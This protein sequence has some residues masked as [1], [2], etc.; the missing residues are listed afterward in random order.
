MS[1]TKSI[2]ELLLESAKAIT[3]EIELEKLVQRVTDI[4]TE[5]SGAQFG[6]FFYNVINQ[7][8][9]AFLLYTIS[10]VAKEAFSKFPN[11]RNTKIFSPT[12]SAEGT[13]RYDDVTKQPEYGQNAPYHGMPKGHL[14]VRSY[15]A[16]PVVSPFTN[17]A[18]GGLFF[19]HPEPGVFTEK[20]ERL[21]EGVAIQAAIAMGNARLFEEK[22]QI[23]R[24][25]M[26]QKE[27]Y[28]SIFNAASDSIII[29]DE[30]GIIAEANPSAC[31]IFGYGYDEL[32]GSHAGRLF[33][34]PQDFE[35]LKEIALSGRQYS[36]TSI[37]IKKDGTAFEAEFKGSHFIFR[38]KPHVMSAVKESPSEREAKEVQQKSEELA[39]I[40]TSAAPVTLWMTNSKAETIYINQTWTDWVG[41][42]R[43]DQLGTGWLN[44]ILPE[45]REQAEKLFFSAFNARK[46]FTSDFRIRRR[47]GE[48][49]WCSTHGTPYYKDGAFA[50]YTGSLTDI[51]DRKL[52]EET[53][54]KQSNLIN[55]I[56]DNTQQAMFLMDERHFCTYMN[57]AAQLM[58]GFT[59]EE[60]KDK[61]LHYYIH[62]TRPDGRHF[63]SD[64]CPIDNSIRQKGYAQGEETFIH[65]DGHFYPVAYVASPI[66]ENGVFKGSVLE[67]RN[68]TEEKRLQQ[69]LR[70]KEKEAMA[71]LEE[72]V[73]ERTSELERS[74][75]ELLQFASVASHDLKE[76]VRKISIFSGRLKDKIHDSLDES[77]SRYLNTIIDSSQRMAGL[78]DDLLSF[79]RLS[80]ADS[81]FEEVDLGSIAQRIIEDLEIPIKEKE[82]EI[83]FRDL[84]VL[85]G[86][87]VQLGQVFQNLVSNSLKF[88]HP[89]R[90]LRIDITCEKFTSVDRTMYRIWYRDNGIGFG[91][92]QA[93]KIFE[94]F[95]RLHSKDKYEGTGVGLA[96]VKKII[97]LHRGEVRAEGVEGEGAVFE[98]VLPEAQ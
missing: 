69:E 73:R 82:A 31:R 26:E 87:P 48:V 86:I 9:E 40:I 77:T 56:T 14:P 75:Y 79:S 21:I 53:L 90:K 15:L 30:N 36:G 96:I 60:L 67:I 44:S 46:V 45:D 83:H 8:G 42:N 23:E 28:L 55:T 18:I 35:A 98:I 2:V 81:G 3:S 6:A 95:Y 10:G 52:A 74:N 78:I 66:I 24:T 89:E 20:S 57:P 70:N 71:M 58:T 84:P 5:L 27:Q 65:K 22:K 62:H 91:P 11:P 16:V 4:G 43:E 61:P 50:G 88:S 19:G 85:Q 93:E 39:N 68:T 92:E 72:K 97:S 34:N 59:V 51:T 76:P 12:F 17:E 49:R 63:P 33:R 32:I 38:G 80:H 37:R 54:E 41:G 29:Y 94:I 7:K 25:L 64:E 47:N 1:T 13:V